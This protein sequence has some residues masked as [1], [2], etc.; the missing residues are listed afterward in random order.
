MIFWVII[1][2]AWYLVSILL[3]WHFWILR[4]FKCPD[5][6]QNYK[7]DTKTNFKYISNNTNSNMYI[8]DKVDEFIIKKTTSD[9][10][11]SRYKLY[12][13]DFNLYATKMF[14]LPKTIA[15]G[16]SIFTLLITIWISGFLLMLLQLLIW[17]YNKG[18]LFLLPMISLL[19]GLLLVYEFAIWVYGS[20]RGRTIFQ[21]A[22]NWKSFKAY[23]E[24]TDHQHEKISH[25]IRVYGKVFTADSKFASLLI[26]VGGVGMS[27]IPILIIL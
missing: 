4:K 23:L 11:V 16:L 26:I 17:H 1:Y 27:F 2:L 19:P 10:K 24:N 3:F 6:L 25:Y 9:K 18:I 20:Y 15:I 14:D 8:Y 12:Y 7:L 21:G 22:A 13:S 5:I